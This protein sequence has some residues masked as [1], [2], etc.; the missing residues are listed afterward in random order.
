MPG[1]R[2]GWCAPSVAALLVS[3]F[4]LVHTA[5]AVQ[6]TVSAARDNTLY[7][8][9]D[10][11]FSNGAGDY[12]FA[13]RNNQAGPSIRRGVIAFDVASA[14]P[15]DSTINGVTLTLYMSRT[16]AGPADVSLHRLTADWG[17]TTTDA[18]G[19]EGSGANTEPGDASWVHT[20]YD[21]QFWATPGGDF[22][23]AVSATTS[24]NSVG[25]YSWTGVGLVADVQSW[26]NNSAQQF[27][28]ILIGDESILHTA[29]R[30]NSRTH[31]TT[32]RRPQLVID[33]TPP[34]LD[35][36]CCLPGDIC[37]VLSEI[38]CQ[39]MSGTYL[40]NGSDC[41][42]DPCAPPTGACCFDD[43]SCQILSEADCATAG[44]MYQG[45]AA[46]CIPGLCPLVLEPFVDALPMPAVLA[47]DVIEPG[48]IPRYN[49]EIVE[50][51]QQ[52]HR[53]LP[54]TRLWGYEGVYPGPTIEATSDQP[55][56]VEWINDIRDEMGILRTE[57]LL[58]VD[59]CPHG[60]NYEGNNP[61]VVTH[62][63]GGHVPS[64]Y[65]GQPENTIL[66]GESDLYEYPNNQGAA[67]IWY[68]DHALGI[69]RLNVYL[70]LAGFY[71]IR[72]ATES[73]LDLPT[74]VYEIPIAIQD[75]SFNPDGSLSYP[76][77]WEEHFHGDVMLANGKVWPYLNVDRGKYRL[78]IV[79]GC[80]SRPLLLSLSN[81]DDFTLI[82]TD[83]GLLETPIVLDTLNLA[84]AERAD[85]I[86]DFAAHSPGTEIIL[87]NSAPSMMPI[88]SVMKFIVGSDAGDTDPVPANLRSIETL[89]EMDASQSRDFVLR[90]VAE[91][92]AG[93]QWLINGMHWDH[94]SEYVTLGDTEI[95][96][97]ANDS[98]AMHPMHMH[99]VMFQVLDR[100]PVM[101]SGNDIIPT[102]PATAPMPTEMG[103]KDTV[104]VG[105]FEAVRVIA[106]FEDYT[107]LFPY[108]CHVLEH[109]DHEMMRQFMVRPACP[110]DLTDNMGMGPDGSVDVFDLFELLANWNADGPGADLAMPH[111]VVDVFD[112]FIMLDAWGACH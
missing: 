91:P 74:G 85:V 45:D 29:K 28:W 24:V 23:P 101:F 67:T 39:G 95:W 33:Y 47:P 6:V 105:P 52:L 50:F 15:A 83:G 56:R 54:P 89:N 112:L 36:A 9:P 17:E 42:G 18:S 13:G 69:T 84:P 96:R 40:G 93:S 79:N 87:Q 61:R 62:L 12:F 68:H 108:H 82:G 53:D 66:P 22:L 77:A 99:L 88:P 11:I 3:V 104:Q 10:G 92:C 102:G 90:K 5:A 81:G 51:Q 1:L 106:R 110:A 14:I 107:G 19:Q 35:G 31:G 37:Q 55:I 94:I 34:A 97:F 8:Y 4:T 65:D 73:S 2:G 44:G 30:F 21:T 63:H 103:W 7:E 71:I 111:D 20:F 72:D 98:G 57:H 43:A 75:R 26:L 25:F 49:I 76:A 100:Q 27:G 59:L 32:T 16:T 41:N 70:G 46:T 109:E 38:D 60:P 64:E 78:R 58:P 48:G 80:N 86:I